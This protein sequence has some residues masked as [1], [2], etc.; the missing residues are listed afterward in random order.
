[1]V[2]VKTEIKSEFSPVSRILA[3]CK[4]MP[5]GISDSLLKKSMPDV[6]PADRAAAINI[7]LS[8]AKI[9]L[10]RLWIL[11]LLISSLSR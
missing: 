5:Q 9:N 7:L 8:E 2:E 10:F 4:E 6:S 3:L 11:R 1:M